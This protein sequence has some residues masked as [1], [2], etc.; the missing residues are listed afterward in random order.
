[1]LSVVKDINIFASDFLY[2]KLYSFV[3]NL[4]K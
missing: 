2:D 1:M 3:G 4:V